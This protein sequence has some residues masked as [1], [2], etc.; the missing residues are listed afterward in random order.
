METL[1]AMAG[2]GFVLWGVFVVFAVI[3]VAYAAWML[4]VE[5]REP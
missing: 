4:R 2:A 1:R 3:V 5:R